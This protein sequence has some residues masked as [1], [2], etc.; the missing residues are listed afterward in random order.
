MANHAILTLQTAN[1]Q[2]G[3]A[4]VHRLDT[5]EA[6]LLVGLY[7]LCLLGHASHRLTPKPCWR[8]RV[9]GDRIER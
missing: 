9:R 1:L 8:W 5:Q 7:A 4:T 6:G 3:V 2:I